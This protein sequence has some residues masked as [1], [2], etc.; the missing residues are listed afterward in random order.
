MA[1]FFPA[2]TGEV[3][4]YLVHEYNDNTI[5]FLL[6][7][8]GS[9]DAAALC[10]AA[11]AVAGSVDILHASF[12]PGRRKARWQLHEDYPQE[13]FFQ[14]LIVSGDPLPAARDFAL[15]SLPPSAPTQ[16][17]CCLVQ[18]DGAA[19]VALIIS[20]LCVDGGDGL[21]LLTKLCEGYSL[22]CRTG[23]CVDLHVK[24]G[25]RRAEQVYENLP[26][27][28]VRKLLY[29]PLSDVKS[30]FPF[31]SGDP[32]KAGMV[33]E[34]VSEPIISAA[35]ERAKECGASAN[36]VL[37][38]ACYRA[39]ASLPTVEADG[40]MSILSMMDLRRHCNGGVSGGLCN[41]SG[42]LPTTLRN[43][44]G[45]SFSETLSAVAAQTRTLK[46]DPLAGLAG[47]PL[48]HGFTRTL[49]L[50][51]CLALAKHVYGSMSLGLT[52]LG[53]ASSAALAL[54]DLFPSAA[55]FGGP[56]KKKPGMQVSVISLDGQCGLSVTG[57]FTPEDEAALSAYLAAVRREIK[58][59]AA[60]TLASV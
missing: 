12:C 40:P 27:S 34:T 33:L 1:Q 11:R 31:P 18:G 22:Y 17:R 42:S 3:M 38:A 24:N 14:S 9:V 58:D 6:R 36:D 45:G 21:Y 28:E 60:L 41:L 46:A 8:E 13:A 44:V 35:R 15:Q 37:L 19:M 20:H 43:G 53:A 47:L 23:S 16:L 2:G 48:I 56:M 7:Y 10:A 25:S 5:R 49:P 52:N 54:E 32:G 29:S 30:T 57:F 4:Q 26:A 39:Y 51:V 55:W 59:F 50:S